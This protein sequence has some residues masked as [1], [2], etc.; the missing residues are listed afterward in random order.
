LWEDSLALLSVMAL[1][2][3]RLRK[4]VFQT[5]LLRSE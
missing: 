5:I 1:G 3:L 2:M 4:I